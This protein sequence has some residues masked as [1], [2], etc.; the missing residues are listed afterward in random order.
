VALAFLTA[1]STLTAASADFKVISAS[2][3]LEDGHFLLDTRIDYEFSDR[4][5]EALDNGV[6]LTLLVHIQVRPAK[7]WV[8]TP[9]LVDQSFRY[10]IRYKPLSESYL[11]TQLPGTSGRSYV[12]RDA[13]IDALG[14][15]RDLHLLNRNRLKPGTDYEVQIRVSLD[16]E[17]LP[18][19]LRPTAYLHPAWK[20]S[21]D[22]THWPLEP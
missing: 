13:A 2:T 14:D 16:V 3:R 11:V 21:S 15:I 19:P 8:W 5:L 6:P 12:S 10:R 18:L 22:W 9:S 4:A 7:S 17:Q 1:F 20:Q